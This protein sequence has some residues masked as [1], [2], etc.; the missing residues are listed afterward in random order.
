MYKSIIVA[1]DLSHA[2][3]GNEILKKASALVAEDGT[4]YLIHV[5]PH[6]PGYVDTYLP[7][8]VIAQSRLDAE[9]RLRQMAQDMGIKARAIIRSGQPHDEILNEADTQNADLIIVA[10]HHPGLTDYLI[11]STAGR[12]VRHAQCSVLVDR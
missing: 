4:L 11:G 1:I 3:R 8:E 5:L 12:V 9:V 2:D 7:E 10:S 6:I